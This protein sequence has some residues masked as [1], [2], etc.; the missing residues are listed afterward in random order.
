MSKPQPEL[1]IEQLSAW[2]K[3][4]G[5]IYKSD[6]QVCRILYEQVQFRVFHPDFGEK[7]FL[8]FNLALAKLRAYEGVPVTRF[9]A[10][11]TEASF[12]VFFPQRIGIRFDTKNA[13]DLKMLEL[14]KGL[15]P[16]P[17]QLFC[18]QSYYTLAEVEALIGDPQN[19]K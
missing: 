4:S 10:S 16:R 8:D 19:V 6:G 15:P 7:D 13:N 2:L 9:L 18:E 14:T 11:Q 12:R 5:Y 17:P 3:A 1:S